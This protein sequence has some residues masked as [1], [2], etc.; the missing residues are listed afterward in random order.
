MLSFRYLQYETYSNRSGDAMRQRI[1]ALFAVV[2]LFALAAPSAWADTDAQKLATVRQMI[3]AWNQRNWQQ[4]YDLFAEDGSLQ[5][6]MLPPTVG[7][8]AIQQRIGALAQGIE[9]IELR[10]RHI[11]ESDGGVGVVRV[12]E[13]VYRGKHGECPVVGVVEV[14]NGH[15]KAW[16]EYY[17]RAQLLEAMGVKE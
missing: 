4:V 6:M 7:R 11:G 13:V 15:V 2:V 12:D 10:V 8:A 14:E 5:S 1:R 17:D 3:D 16:R 9:S